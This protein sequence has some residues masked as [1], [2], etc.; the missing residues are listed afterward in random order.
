MPVKIEIEQMKRLMQ[1]TMYRIPCFSEKDTQMLSGISDAST[2]K[3]SFS[4]AAACMKS[5]KKIPGVLYV[6]LARQ[7]FS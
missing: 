1:C 2:F 4:Y 5:S 3:V 7:R 6:M